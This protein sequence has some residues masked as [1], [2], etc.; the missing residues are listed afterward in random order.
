MVTTEELKRMIQEE[1]D[2]KKEAIA[3][4]LKAFN[5][6]KKMRVDVVYY[7][8]YTPCTHLSDASEFHFGNL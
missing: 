2:E 4:F 6:L 5:E 7:S 3:N 1:K 8:F